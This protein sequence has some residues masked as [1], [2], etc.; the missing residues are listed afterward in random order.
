MPLPNDVW[1]DILWMSYESLSKQDLEIVIDERLKLL[2]SVSSTS[3]DLSVYVWHMQADLIHLGAKFAPCMRKDAKI[4]KEIEKGREKERETACCIRNDDSGCVQSSQ[5]DCSV[6]MNHILRTE[7][8]NALLL[9]KVAVYMLE[10]PV[11]AN[12]DKNLRYQNFILCLTWMKWLD[13]VY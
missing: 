10:Q 8:C 1:C 7:T 9:L 4:I 6:S 5:A 2:R 3:S 13:G 11:S 12:C